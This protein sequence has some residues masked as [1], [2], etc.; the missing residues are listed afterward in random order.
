MAKEMIIRINVANGQII[1]VKDEAGNK[2]KE[3]SM[4][5]PAFVMHGVKKVE[6]TFVLTQAS[7]VCQYVLLGGKYYYL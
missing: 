4:N 1:D 7:P 3:G 2:A 5:D 6:G